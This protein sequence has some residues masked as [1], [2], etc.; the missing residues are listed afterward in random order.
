[1]TDIR[2]LISNEVVLHFAELVDPHST[3]NR[4][5]PSVSVAVTAMM[6]VRA[7]ARGPAVIAEGPSSRRSSS[8]WRRTSPTAS[9]A[10]MSPVAS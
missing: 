4:R 6:A 10:W 1:M 8:W 3:V 9:P 5:H 7:G 2:R